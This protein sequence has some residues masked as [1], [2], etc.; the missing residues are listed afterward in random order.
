[1]NRRIDTIGVAVAAVLSLMVLGHEPAIAA[2]TSARRPN[3]VW[4]MSEDNSAHYMDMYFKSGASTPRIQQMAT[5]GVVFNH[6]FCVAPVCSAARSILATGC[7]GSRIGTQFH[8]GGLPRPGLPK[9]VKPVYAV[10]SEAGY[11]T[12]NQKK[13]DYNYTWKGTGWDGGGDWR[14]KKRKPGQPF[15]FKLT[16]YGSHESRLHRLRINRRDEAKGEFVAPIHPDTPVFRQTHRGYN[17]IMTGID[18]EVGRVVDALKEDGLLEDTFIF[19]F[20]DNGGVL[21]G[22]KGYLYETGIHI[23][24][25]VRIPENF[26]HL[27]DLKRG[28]R[29]DGFVEFIDFGATIM[30][31][32]GIAPPA[33]IDGKP[34][35]GP[36]ISKADLEARDEAFG[37]ADRMDEKYD[38][39]RTL[40]KGD[41]KYMRSYQP[42]NFDGLQNNYRYK[43]TAYR[44]WRE[45]Y[46]AGKLNPVQ[47]QFFEPREPEALYDVVKDPYE[48]VNLAKDP[49]YADQLKKLRA[50]L[51]ERMKGMPDL[52]MYP[53]SHLLQ[54]AMQGP[55]EFGQK[56]K[57][58]IAELVD[59]ADL[60]LLPFSEARAGIAAA[61]KSNNPWKR[62]WGMTA[63]SCLM[64]TAEE[65]VEDA[66]KLAADDENLLVRTRAVE[67]LALIGAQDPGPALNDIASK[68]ENDYELLLILNTAVMLKDG[69]PGYKIMI[70][71]TKIQVSLRP[72]Y[73][74]SFARLMYL[75]QGLD[76][77]WASYGFYKDL[78]RKGGGKKR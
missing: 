31:L 49:A 71:P 55:V 30:H 44:E 14:N 57:A 9:D 2:G 43:M 17:Q 70:D 27:V 50:R 56:H 63:C 13:T 68:S 52:S 75:H 24:L 15:F 21:P 74:Q 12:T 26:K 60:S 72:G 11:F 3:F 51:A 59:T 4:L 40:R 10:M 67:F 65:F 34:F 76:T 64:K 62:Y 5:D 53:E 47:A 18:T 20:G 54:H 32:A 73:S 42:F 41:L 69:K 19:Y 28:T 16:I 66:K 29:A 77:P 46:K 22:S 33:G 38:L 25:V 58:E 8:R 35:M 7:Y 23:P 48:T 45:L 78:Y 61:L 6:A 1:M 36:G 39:V 37:M